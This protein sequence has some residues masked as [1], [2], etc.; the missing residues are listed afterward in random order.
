MRTTV[1]LLRHGEVH[2]PTGILYGRRPGFVT[3]GH[4]V[5]HPAGTRR[6]GI[7]WA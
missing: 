7:R 5:V 2:N 6:T 3:S 4:V 1:H